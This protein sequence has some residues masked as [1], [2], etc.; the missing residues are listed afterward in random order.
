MKKLIF[1]F[2]FLLFATS[3]SDDSNSEEYFNIENFPQIW[4]LDSMNIGLSGQ[5]LTGE[6]LPYQ[7]KIILQIDGSFSKSRDTAGELNVGKGSFS[8]I[9]MDNRKILSMT[10][11]SETDLISSCIGEKL[12][13][14]LILT[15]NSSLSGGSLLCDGPGLYYKPKE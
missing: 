4:I 13:E 14:K 10:Y 2:S 5:F 3:C 15:T 7:E 12:V 8:F 6:D 9:N 11:D 1:Y